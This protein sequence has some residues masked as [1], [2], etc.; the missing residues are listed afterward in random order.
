MPKKSKNVPKDYLRHKK[1][2]ALAIGARIRLRRRKLLLSQEELRKKLQLE[3]VYITRSQFS[4]LESG[5][6]LPSAVEIIALT[7]A[8]QASYAWLLLGEKGPGYP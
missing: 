6:N 3:G 5:K 8:L 2:T 7:S 4:R 1:Q